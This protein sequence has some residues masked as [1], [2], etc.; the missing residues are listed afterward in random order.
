MRSLKFNPQWQKREKTTT[1]KKK[2]RIKNE[3][4]LGM[5]VYPCNPPK[6]GEL[7][8]KDYVFEASLEFIANPWPNV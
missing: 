4:E 1:T 8:Q 6:F 5:V 3:L 2:T 7:R